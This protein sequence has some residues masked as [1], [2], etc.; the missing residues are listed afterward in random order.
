M[1]FHSISLEK[2]ESGLHMLIVPE[3]QDDY[4]DVYVQV[5]SRLYWLNIVA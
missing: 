5:S 1:I 2:N 3:N 4:F